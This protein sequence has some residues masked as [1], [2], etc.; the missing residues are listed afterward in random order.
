M[1]QELEFEEAVFQEVR[2]GTA[3]VCLCPWL[4][5]PYRLVS[6]L[7]LMK[8]FNVRDLLFLAR[9]LQNQAS[10]IFESPQGP[11]YRFASVDSFRTKLWAFRELCQNLELPMSALHASQLWESTG[12]PVREQL[13]N[14]QAERI[15]N[16]LAVT[17]EN[18]LSLR[19]YFAVPPEKAKFYGDNAE[20]FGNTVATAFPSTS[21]DAGEANRCFALSRATACVFHLMRTLEIALRVFAD[22]F[23]VPSDHTNW[24]NVIEGIE[25]AVRNMGNDPHRAADWK[26]QQ[27]FFSQA[28]SHF[29]FLKD[30]WRN[31]TA[32]ARGKYTDEEAETLII[33]V[34]AFVQKLAT[35]LHE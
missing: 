16:M 5:N 20:P 21:F 11:E 32:H 24:H 15:S 3:P 26:D 22:R 18:E 27:E 19:L 35:R 8:A 33:N 31:Y 34:R 25:K 30:A 23:S 2:E 14:G 13:D 1:I 29:M 17:V 4:E 7:E 10:I 9:G 28:A 12:S 6:L